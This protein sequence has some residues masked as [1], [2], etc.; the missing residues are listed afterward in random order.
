VQIQDA[1]VAIGDRGLR[2]CGKDAGE[3]ETEQANGDGGRRA[4][5]A[6][7]GTQITQTQNPSTRAHDR[8]AN[9]T[10]PPDPAADGN[11]P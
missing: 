4:G 11:T 10:Q 7:A 8:S 5:Q 1:R 9:R 6:E 2:R 3:A